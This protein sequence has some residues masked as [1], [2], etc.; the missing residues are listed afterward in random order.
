MSVAISPIQSNYSSKGDPPAFDITVPKDQDFD[1]QVT[2]VPRLFSGTLNSR[3]FRDNFFSS[4]DGSEGI[5]SLRDQA[6]ESPFSYSLPG[7]AW[8]NLQRSF[9]RSPFLYYRARTV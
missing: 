7:P 3:R 8:K 1:V 6:K 4:W 9:R 5:P 2:T